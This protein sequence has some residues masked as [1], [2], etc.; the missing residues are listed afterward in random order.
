[1]GLSGWLGKCEL[2][3]TYINRRVGRHDAVLT[4]SRSDRRRH[5]L[6]VQRAFRA[7]AGDGVLPD[8]DI[9]PN[10]DILRIRDRRDYA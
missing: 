3:L 5:Q 1:M 10:D 9:L 2:A 6:L 8:D 7:H 4:Q